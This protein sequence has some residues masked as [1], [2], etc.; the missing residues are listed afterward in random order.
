MDH[1]AAPTSIHAEVSRIAQAQPHDVALVGDDG[2]VLSY[3]Q[4]DALTSRW[5]VE[6]TERGVKPGDIVPLLM[7]RSSSLVAVLLAILKSGAAYAP[8]DPRW[9]DSRIASLIAELAPPLLV[10]DETA[11]RFGVPAWRV[12][13]LEGNE[14]GSTVP[15]PP[16][17]D[18]GG[19]SPACVFFTS[20]TSGQPKAVVS[21]HRATLRLF[22]PG[23]PLAFGPGRRMAQAAPV[24]WD[25]FSLEVWGMLTTGGSCVI[26][27][28]DHLLPH[29]LADLV[30]LH[31]VNTLWMTASLFNVFVADEID[32]FTGLQTLYT[33]GERL[34]PRHVRMFI[35][36]H[37]TIQL[38]NGYGPVESC[39]FATCH[40]ITLDDCCAP[41]GIPIG[42]PV[43]STRIFV[44]DGSRI[45][46]AGVPG[47]LCIAGAGLAL[48]YL[49]DEALT[50][51]K[52]DDLVV[53]GG[54]VRIYRTGDQGLRDDD[55]VYHFI[56]RNDRQLKV[57]GHRIE[58]EEVEAHAAAVEGV[59]ACAAVAIP[60]REEEYERIALYY[61]LIAGTEVATSG[62]DPL[63]VRERLAQRIPA[64]LLPAVAQA[65]REIPLTDT[66]KVDYAVL[67]T[68]ERPAPRI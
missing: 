28:D 67:G 45:C 35:E 44:V 16:G 30:S 64:Y 55:G 52:F 59:L 4:L 29:R 65:V 41:H 48:G 38:Y 10:A 14:V 58:L 20:G 7:P 5:S 40:A 27:A 62:L 18:V 68:W 23:G 1:Y 53:D 57:R 25:A 37:P 31:S 51:S 60:G 56:G 12:P 13:E 50:R 61:T 66:G 63:A 46:P 42:E 36:Q 9:P 15:T 2:A 47:E 19:D 3:G 49:G 43:P 24:A 6:L 21:P 8:L 17:S 26:V 11:R 34:S 54:N 22:A 39:V 32:C 33:G